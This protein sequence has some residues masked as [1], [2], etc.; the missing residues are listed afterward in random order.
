MGSGQGSGS[1]LDALVEKDNNGLPFIGGKMLKG[2]LRDA[3]NRL[4][5]WQLLDNFKKTDQLTI[6]ESLFGSAGF[7]QD[8]KG[9]SVPRNKTIQGLV[10]VNDATLIEDLQQWLA[11]PEQKLQRQQLFTEMYTTAINEKGTAKNKS[12]RGKQVTIPLT[13]EVELEWLGKEENTQWQAI[14]AEGLPLIRAVGSQRSR[15]YGRA[16]FSIKPRDN[17]S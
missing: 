16:Q 2:L 15:G 12:L 11:H 10:R 7:S 1:H 14:I 5:Q 9:N 17:A 4:E 3:I 8:K 13:L 6:T